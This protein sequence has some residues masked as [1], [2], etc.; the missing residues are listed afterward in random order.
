MSSLRENLYISE[1]CTYLEQRQIFIEDALFIN[2]FIQVV[3]I[4]CFCGQIFLDFALII[5]FFA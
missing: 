2:L 4:F 1:M 5:D 3:K